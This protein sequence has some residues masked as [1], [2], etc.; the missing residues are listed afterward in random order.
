MSSEPVKIKSESYKS[1][2]GGIMS[3]AGMAIGLGNVWRFPYMVGEF[4][5]GAFVFAYLIC[6][7]LVVI[8]CA[9][10]E[11]GYGKLTSKG[12]MEAYEAALKKKILGKILGGLSALFYG[13]QNFFFMAVIATSVYFM[14]VCTTG[15]WNRVPATEIYDSSLSN[16]GIMFVLVIALTLAMGF[17]VIKGVGS[18][19]EKISKVFIPLMFL[20]LALVVI[21]TPFVIDNIGIGY[22][23]YLNPDFSALLKPSIWVAA[24]GQACLSVGLG[25]GCLLIYGSHIDKD[26]DATLSAVNVCLLDSAVAVLAGMAII[27][28]CVALGLDPESGARLIFV[29]LPAVFEQIPMGNL[30]GLFMMLAIFFA[31]F[32]TATAQMEVPV[33]TFMHGFKLSRFKVTAVVTILTII[34][35]CISV[36]NEAFLTFWSTL[37]GNY[38]FLITA[39][40]G[41][42]TWGWIYGVDRIRTESLNPSGDVQLGRWYTVWTKYVAIPL[43]LFV[44]LNSLFPFFG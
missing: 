10:M 2:F 7:V 13:S 16:Y 32:T 43:L 11:A 33:V 24:M 9:I 41:C 34:C 23:F 12:I 15:M 36:Y 27:P 17:I 39:A 6:V 4:G 14:Y 20:F 1:K 44:L 18:G 31:G 25:P 19:I 40:M 28:A 21:V 37:A 30:I 42:I 3:M 22:D 29:V 8:P 26:E 38:A 35:G 5:G